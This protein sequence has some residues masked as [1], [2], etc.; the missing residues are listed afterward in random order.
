[1]K[2]S[3]IDVQGKEWFD[4]TYGNSYVAIRLYINYGMKD[5]V[6]LYGPYTY[7][8]GDYYMQYARELLYKNGYIENIEEYCT[9]STYCRENKIILRQSKENRC[10]KND[11]RMWGEPLMSR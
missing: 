3:T 9:L 6:T 4:R 1:M 11:V 2:I 7:G 8:Y 5:D 10:L